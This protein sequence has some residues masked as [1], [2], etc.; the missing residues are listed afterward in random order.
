MKNGTR[1][2][3][4]VNDVNFTAP[5]EVIK[6]EKQHSVEIIGGKAYPILMNDCRVSVNYET[7]RAQEQFDTSKSR[8]KR[9]KHR[10]S[11]EIYWMRMDL[12]AVQ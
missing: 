10:H 2:S 12:T 5:K 11:F 7:N 9:I 6:K 8:G 1:F 3:F 4:D